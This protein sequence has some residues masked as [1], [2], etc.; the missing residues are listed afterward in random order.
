MKKKQGGGPPIDPQALDDA[1]ALAQK[2]LTVP[3]PADTSADDW[4]KLTAAAYPIFHSAIALDDAGSK[5]DMKAAEGEYSSEL[6]L[7]SDDQSKS[8]GLQDT[9]LLAQAYGTPGASQDLVKAVWFYAR[10]WDFAPPAYKTKIEPTLEYLYKK[11][12]GSLDGL[13]AIKTQAAK[14]PRRFRRAVW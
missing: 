5:K 4:K 6:M 13:D 7:F 11:Y 8:S 10:V 12:H 1:A 9:L 14:P 2:G 3:K